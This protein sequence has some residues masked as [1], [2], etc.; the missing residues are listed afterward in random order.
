MTTIQRKREK[1]KKIIV[2]SMILMLISFIVMGMTGLVSEASVRL[3]SITGLDLPTRVAVDDAGNIYVTDPLK[4]RM[5]VFGRDGAEKKVLYGLNGPLAVAVDS[6]G[7]IYIGN[8]NKT[9]A[10]G[11]GAK[12]SVD[13]YSAAYQYQYSL[14]RGKGEFKKP[15]A[16][17]IHS[18]GS[19][20]VTDSDAHM[21]KIYSAEGSLQKTFGVWGS[22]NGSG[23]GEF[24]FPAG[25]AID[26][27]NAE[28]YVSDLGI[29]LDPTNGATMGARVQVFDLSGGFKRSFGEYGTGDGKLIRPLGIAYDEGRLYVADTFQSVVQV[30]DTTGSHLETLYDLAHEMGAPVGIAVGGDNRIFIASSGTGSIEIYGADNYTGLSVAPKALSFRTQEGVDPAAQQIII[31]NSGPGEM[32]WGIETDAA[33]ISASPAGGSTAGGGSTSAAVGI[34]AAGLQRGSYSGTVTVRTDGAEETVAVSLEVTSPPVL[35]VGPSAL[36]FRAQAGG[37]APASQSISIGISND[38]TGAASWS[39]ASNAPWLAVS[40]AAGTSA[41]LV[42]AAVSVSTAGLGAGT[43]Q[44]VIS[45]ESAGATGSPGSVAVSLELTAAGAITVKTNLSES[46]FSISGAA[47]YSGG[48]QSWSITDAPAGQYRITFNKVSGFKTPAS[49]GFTVESGKETV[50]SGEY[51]DLRATKKVVAGLGS[52]Q[53]N[54]AAV[55]VLTTDGTA[56]GADFTAFSLRYGANVA[57]GDLDGDGIDELIVGAGAGWSNPARVKVF[58]ADGSEIAGLD[59]IAFTGSNGVNVAAGDL[60][61]DGRAEIIAGTTF[62]KGGIAAVRAF[63]VENGMIADTGI[64]FM[65]STAMGGVPVA[66]GDIDGDGTAEIITGADS[67]QSYGRTPSAVRTWK[68]RKSVV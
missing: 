39:A 25:I 32:S 10:S 4:N 46:S 21:V 61:G 37:A 15:N 59:F 8:E 20:Y 22:L 18:N 33:W 65:T 29:Y 45:V 48:G 9:G 56:A 31:G 2:R 28:V 30:F 68:D 27:A 40:P 57:A 66:A 7:R 50:I 41:A 35:S 26:E 16:I 17:A 12:G 11:S 38:T 42:T 23:P 5:K 13:V 43:Y 44:G 47:A 63:R 36:S 64:N 53:A 3:G 52:V 55:K 51:R 14:G 24:N 62:S 19:I 67:G 6:A 58:R 49:Q 54:A 34:S 60:D 1:M